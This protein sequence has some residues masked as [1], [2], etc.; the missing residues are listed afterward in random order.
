MSELAALRARWG[1]RHFQRAPAKLIDK[2]PLHDAD[3]T[4]LTEIGLPVG[5]RTALKLSLRFEN[6]NILH[7][8]LKIKPASAAGFKKAR[9]FPRTGHKNLGWADLDKFV[10]VGKVPPEFG[11]GNWVGRFIC[12]DGGTG[13]VAWAAPDRKDGKTYISLMNTNLTAYLKSLLAY[14]E[15]REEWPGLIKKYGGDEEAA[16][17]KG[18]RKRAT[19][20]HKNFTTRLKRADP[21]GYKNQDGFWAFHAWN[22][23]ILLGIG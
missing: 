21:K 2:L 8:P 18:Y 22:E 7:E 11:L 4:I 20:I 15:F 3:K 23:A 1:A 16:E 17:R 13:R 14:K 12:I 19:A 5:P 10:V 9:K 6:V